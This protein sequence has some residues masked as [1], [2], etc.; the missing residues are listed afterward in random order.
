MNRLCR[1]TNHS[2]ATRRSLLVALLAMLTC[3]PIAWAETVDLQHAASVGMDDKALE[4][5]PQLMQKFVDAGQASGVVT[6]VARKGKVV[7]NAAV[8]HAD[9]NTHRP[10]QPDTVFAIASMTKP[11]TSTALMILVDEGKVSIDDPVSKYVPEF[12]QS[13]LATG[14]PKRRSPFATC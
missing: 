8:G 3:A 6:L 9:I 5:I 1:G 11:I 14:T 12:K 4:R 13:V 7:L 2:Q 10:M